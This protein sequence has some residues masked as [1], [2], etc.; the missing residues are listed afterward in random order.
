MKHLYPRLAWLVLAAGLAAVPV[1]SPARVQAAPARS[2]VPDPIGLT[3]D[4]RK[5]LGEIQKRGHAEWRAVEYGLGSPAEKSKKLAAIQKKYDAQ[6]RAILT[7]QQ[8]AKIEELRKKQMAGLQ[9]LANVRNSLTKEQRTKMQDIRNRYRAQEVAV[10][11][12]AKLPDAEKR[13][14]VRALEV[15]QSREFLAVLTP[16]QRASLGA[17]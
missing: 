16:A 15:A 9:K 8:R 2:A 12:N 5:K 4:Q 11:K 14:Q 17:K 3:L 13:K 10:V 6:A 1:F 7:P